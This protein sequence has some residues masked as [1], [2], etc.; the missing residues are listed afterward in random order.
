MSIQTKRNA[1]NSICLGAASTRSNE[2][3]FVMY[4]C[5][6]ILV[7]SDAVGEH[8]VKESFARINLKHSRL[9]LGGA[10]IIRHTRVALLQRNM[11]YVV[12]TKTIDPVETL[13]AFNHGTPRVSHTAF[14]GVLCH[15]WGTMKIC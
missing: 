1:L 5:Y 14:T 8:C 9:R 4:L 15:Y 3:D 6:K 7:G 10:S 2:M 13:E 11:V 12:M